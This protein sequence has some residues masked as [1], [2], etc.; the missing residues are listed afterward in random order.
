MADSTTD[1]TQIGMMTDPTVY[2]VSGANRGIGL[3]FVTALAN[4]ENVIVFAGARDPSAASALHGLQEAH[5]G[6]VYLVKL[7]SADETGNR[8]AIQQIKEKVGRL[9]V[10]IANAGISKFY[11]S[12]LETPVQEMHDHYEVN[13]IGTLVLFQAAYPLMK[14]STLKPKFVPISS[15][16][17]SLAVGSAFP[18]GHLAYGASK[19]AENYLARK[20]HYEN[21]DLICVPLC[22]GAVE[23]DLAS[24]GAKLEKGEMM[25]NL[26]LSTPAQTV[27]RMLPM[28]D[29]AERRA[30][31]PVLMRS[32][33]EVRPW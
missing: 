15:S 11:G 19:A 3:G 33:G 7:V 27:A 32:I 8:A 4:R 26:P 30:D 16:A 13:V 31:G 28:I 1:S 17:G 5:P 21:E 10:V 9:D 6:K 2:L 22:P 24:L 18:M 14:A 12:A 23:T 29:D 25:Q 20:L